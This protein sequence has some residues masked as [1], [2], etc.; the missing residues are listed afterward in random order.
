MREEYDQGP[1]QDII[2]GKCIFSRIPFLEHGVNNGMDPFDGMPGICVHRYFLSMSW[3]DS[4]WRELSFSSPWKCTYNGEMS[5]FKPTSLVLVYT[6]PEWSR[7]RPVWGLNYCVVE[8]ISFKATF[9]KFWAKLLASRS[10]WINTM[11][12]Q[13]DVM[14]ELV[15]YVAC[16]KSCWALVG[17]LPAAVDINK[18]LESLCLFVISLLDELSNLCTWWVAS[19]AKD[20]I[21][22]FFFL[23][24]FLLSLH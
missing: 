6:E 23:F 8:F 4:T 9:S 14:T 16:L 18:L 3:W 19:V 11:H 13:P 24:F 21:F 10:Q 2:Q 22:I 17:W 12:H 5:V 7:N 20:S 1:S 15:L